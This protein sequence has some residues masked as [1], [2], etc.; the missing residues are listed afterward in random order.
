MTEAASM[1]T[2]VA[3]SG[4][5]RLVAPALFAILLGAFLVLGAGF[6]PIATLHDAAHDSRHSLA[7]PCH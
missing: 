7:F 6:A 4:D 5:D 2:T 1:R 3:A